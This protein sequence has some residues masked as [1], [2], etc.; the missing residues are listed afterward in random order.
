[1]TPLAAILG[2]KSADLLAVEFDGLGARAAVCRRDGSGPPV[3]NTCV[4]SPIVD[5]TAAL[6][7]LTCQLSAAGSVVPRQAVLL[8][9]LVQATV[10]HLPVDP[11]KPLPRRNMQELIRWELEPYLAQHRARR[12]GAI[13][14]GRR[15]L[16]CADLE[17]LLRQAEWPPREAADTAGPAR[18]LGELAVDAGMVTRSQVDE[19]LDLQRSSTDFSGEAACGWAPLSN[20]PPDDDSNWLYLACGTPHSFRRAA[21]EAFHHHG[22]Q[23]R[24]LYPLV[25]CARATLNGELDPSAAV[26]E[27]CG[28]YL[29]YTRL[30]RRQ[31][32]SCRTVFT[33]DAGNPMKACLQLV[34]GEADRVWLAGNWPDLD[35]ATEELRSHL[36]RPVDAVPASAAMA[37]PCGPAVSV[38]GLRGAAAHHLTRA[39]TALACVPAGETSP[40]LWARRSVVTAT[41]AVAA[42]VALLA[43]ASSLR[44]HHQAAERELTQRT[45]LASRQASVASRQTSANELR[46]SLELLRDTIPARQRLIPEAFDALE[47]ACPPGVTVK[48]L[49]E[50]VS[51][52]FLL[53]GSGHTA[54]E[55]QQF[56]IALQRRL[57][58][59]T[60]T[61]SGQPIRLENRWQNTAGY[62][63]EWKLTPRGAAAAV[64]PAQV[65]P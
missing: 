4:A 62:T 51:G 18:R 27:Y 7:D 52:T 39:G 21:V 32:A 6:A 48:Q 17:R 25:G 57:P 65:R 28:G 23:L 49:R 37:A 56:M 11:R 3:V 38:A 42:S 43:L 15:Y 16:S 22:L 10:L 5:L 33:H 41:V 1:M 2:G 31:V 58:A 44:Q 46:K 30:A 19:C 34:D 20:G 45:D 50:T 29:S 63:F 53:T 60:V 14:V 12:I 61:D 36:R 64:A 40:V 47:E 35:A 54:Q 13:L 26:F 8:S 55:V 59:M 24:A 9:P